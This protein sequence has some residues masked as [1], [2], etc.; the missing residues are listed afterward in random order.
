M[1]DREIETRCDD[2]VARV[3]AGAPSVLRRSRGYV[4]RAI[5]LRTPVRRPVLA[6]GADLKNTFCIAFSDSAYLGP[7][8]G[9]LGGLETY[10]SLGDSIERMIKFLKVTPE[11]VAHDL[12][13]DSIATS[14]ARSRTEPR[15]AVQ[16]HHAHIVSAMAEHGIEGPVIGVAYD[17]TGYGT[18]GT[19]W[20]GEVLLATTREY[21][22]LATLRPIPLAGG[23]KA[24]RDVWRIA[25]AALDDAFDG[26][27]PI[28]K[29]ALFRDIPPAEIA[30]VR[31]M[32]AKGVNVPL[33]RGV[34][35]W[36]DAAGAIGLGRARATYEG[37]AAIE[38]NNAAAGAIGARYGF[39]IDEARDPIEL[40]LRP[41]I[42]AV[43]EDLIHDRPP[44]FIAAG[45][46]DALALATAGLV[47]C[48]AKQAG[49]LPVVLSGGCFQNARLAQTVRDLLAPSFDVILHRSVPSGD[50]GIAL[51][52]AVIAAAR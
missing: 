36:F 41:V 22:R 12:H 38:W 10:R 14:Y 39:T 21:T 33:A 29:L 44:A 37:Q 8:I 30:G 42:R 13:P 28:E 5:P 23:E 24:I 34:G 11:I 51:G 7:H 52:Q 48:A 16:H 31:Q 17:G 49:R 2:S 4:P 20:G 19:L 40:D 45:F 9:D 32:I 3:I 15:V 25:L 43:A 1:H 6:V 50:G 35:R 27:A 46:H 47:R 26:A 18:D